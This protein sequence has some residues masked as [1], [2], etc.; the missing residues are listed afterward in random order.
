MVIFIIGITD[1]LA[2][3]WS[4]VSHVVSV[5]LCVFVRQVDNEQIYI[6]MVTYANISLYV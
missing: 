2:N 5:R 6:E 4:L 3:R 1:P